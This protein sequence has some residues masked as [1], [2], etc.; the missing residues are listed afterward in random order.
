[1]L[2][3]PISRWHS[4]IIV[5]FV[6]NGG[7]FGRF[8]SRMLPYCWQI[9]GRTDGGESRANFVPCKSPHLPSI[10]TSTP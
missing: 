8:K 2:C 1:M 4:Q 7:D 6:R 3:T 10:P 9:E 5:A